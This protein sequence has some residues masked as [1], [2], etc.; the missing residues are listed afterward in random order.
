MERI[1][2]PQA[3]EQYRN[4]IIKKRD[5]DQPCITVCTGTGCHA[6][7]CHQVVEA[8]KKVLADHPEGHRVN[9]RMTGCH[10]FCE[11]GP[12]VVLHPQKILYQKVKPENAQEIL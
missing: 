1:S 7:G 8:F 11:K 2:S 4:E 12:L 3:L 6:S 10:G 9:L 5:P